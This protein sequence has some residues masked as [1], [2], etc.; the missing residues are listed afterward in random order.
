MLDL[1]TL[2]WDD[3]RTEE[4]QTHI[5]DGLTPGRVALQ[6]RGAWDVLTAAGPLRCDLAGRLRD[7]L[8]PGDRPTVGD[9][10][11]VAARPTERAGTVQAVLSRR[12]KFSRKVAGPTSDE[13]VVAANIDVVF[14]VS[15][16]N[17]DLNPRR[18]ERYLTLGWDSGARPVVVLTKADLCDD[19]PAVVAGIEAI[20]FGAD[21][22][23][24]TAPTGEGLDRIRDHLG[25]GVTGALL[26]S[27]GVGKST[28]VNAL[29][30][31][32]ILA[33]GDIREDDGRG[34]HTTTRRQLVLLPD[35]GLV[36]DTPGMRELQLWA[37]D[38]GLDDAFRDI[39]GLAEHCRFSDCAHESEP[40]C[41]V[42]AALES[43]ELASDR[44]ESYRKLQRELVRLERRVD[45]RASTLERRRWGTIARE[46]RE[47]GRAKRRE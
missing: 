22:V 17:E 45:R 12:T 36:I 40:D 25:P 13:Q 4:F 35:G 2:G 26:G 19:V 37:A 8:P 41:A 38:D 34:R 1:T 30:G 21:V 28:L 27:S 44:W 16:L 11:A 20:T 43:G 39:S 32:E 24:V 42:R 14:I 18:L 29:V 47:V 46:A 33:T 31:S 15:S 3:Q 10:L 6:Y 23:V 7:T 9:W 5:R